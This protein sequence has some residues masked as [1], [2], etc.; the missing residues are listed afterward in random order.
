[1]LGLHDKKFALFL[2]AF[3]VQTAAE[4]VRLAAKYE[5]VRGD[6]KSRKPS[7]NYLLHLQIEISLRQNNDLNVSEDENEEELIATLADLKVRR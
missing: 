4:A 6:K 7:G 2:K 3:K 5:V 1:M